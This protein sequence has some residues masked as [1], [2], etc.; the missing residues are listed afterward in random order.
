MRHWLRR[1]HPHDRNPVPLA[2]RRPPAIGH[3]IGGRKESQYSDEIAR[4]ILAR[5][6]AGESVDS[7]LADPAMPSRRTLYDWLLDQP[8]FGEAWREMRADQ[9]AARREDVCRIEPERRVL[10]LVRARAKGGIPRRK[11]GRKSTY[12][13]CKGLFLG[14]LIEQ[15][16]TVRGACTVV[17]V[18]SQLTFYTWLRNHP[19]FRKTYVAALRAR[20]AALDLQAQFIVEGM[21]FE[22][23]PALFRLH[24]RRVERLEGRIGALKPDVWRWD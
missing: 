9:A 19:A 21:D 10:A 13:A 24:K 6:E 2:R 16:A 5:I 7:L 15:G 17:G 22:M 18:A 1:P 11:V 12:T 8:D 4:I 14:F 23:P 3:A 20:E